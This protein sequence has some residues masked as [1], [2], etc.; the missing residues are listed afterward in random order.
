MKVD[1]R[2]FVNLGDVPNPKDELEADFG[3]FAADILRDVRRKS[4]NKLSLD[5]MVEEHLRM[6]DYMLAET[7]STEDLVGERRAMADAWTLEEA[8]EDQREFEAMLEKERFNDLNLEDDEE[9]QG[10]EDDDDE[11]APLLG[12]KIDEDED[13]DEDKDVYVDEDGEAYMEEDED[14]NVYEDEDG[15]LYV[16]EDEDEDEDEDEMEQ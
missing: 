15:K 11:F 13:E 12:S 16:Y 10:E 6:T 7:G 9:Y 14:Q 8:K 2:L 1:P 4:M 5:E 3:P